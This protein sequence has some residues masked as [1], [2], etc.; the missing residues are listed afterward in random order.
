M[1]EFA[2]VP[3]FLFSVCP[4]LS[5]QYPC[6]PV[7]SEVVEAATMIFFSQPTKLPL[8]IPV[9]NSLPGASVGCHRGVIHFVFLLQS[10]LTHSLMSLQW[11]AQYAFHIPLISIQKRLMSQLF[12]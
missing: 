1:N 10:I 3:G 8:F 4:P 6:A 2:I 9:H 11:M 7:R 12:R 5:L